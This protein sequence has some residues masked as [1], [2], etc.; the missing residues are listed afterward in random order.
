MRWIFLSRAGFV[1]L[2]SLTPASVQSAVP[3]TSILQT[4]PQP[5]AEAFMGTIPKNGETF[6]LSDSVTRSRYTLDNPKKASLYEGKIRPV[7]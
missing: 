7:I 1:T 2:F 3:S 4:K 6:V 5:E